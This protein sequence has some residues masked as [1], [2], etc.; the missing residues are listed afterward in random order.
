MGLG[1]MTIIVG[2]LGAPSTW[3]QWIVLAVMV[4]VMMLWC[5]YILNKMWPDLVTIEVWF[6]RDK[7]RRFPT[8]KEALKLMDDE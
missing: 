6:S 2:V 1:I 4:D 8:R 7:K 3:L 5:V